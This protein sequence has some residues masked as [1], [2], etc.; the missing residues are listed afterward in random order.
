MIL[1][2]LVVA[3]RSWG[4][5]LPVAALLAFPLMMIG[6]VFMMGA[7]RSHGLGHEHGET[8]ERDTV[9]AASP[10]GRGGADG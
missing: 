2:V 3:G 10:T 4:E 9:D 6:M 1:V 7:T 8:T 5:A